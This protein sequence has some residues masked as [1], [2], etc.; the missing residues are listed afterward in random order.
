MVSYHKLPFF[1]AL[2]ER[3]SKSRLCNKIKTFAGDF[4][5]ILSPESVLTTTGGFRGVADASFLGIRPPHQPKGPP[6]D[7]TL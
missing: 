4:R 6:F 7:N 2:I 3:L 5:N 1:R